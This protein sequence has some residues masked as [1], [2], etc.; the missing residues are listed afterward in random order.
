ARDHNDKNRV[1]SPL[2]LAPDAI[3]V[4]NT[5]LSFNQTFGLVLLFDCKALFG[6]SQHRFSC[7]FSPSLLP[8]P[9]FLIRYC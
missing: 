3:V 7:L 2:K 9:L 8:L 4:D 5:K 6:V 1:L